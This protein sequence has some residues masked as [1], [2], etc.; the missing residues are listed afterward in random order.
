MHD[1]ILF[2][3]LGEQYNPASSKWAQ[4]IVAPCSAKRKQKHSRNYKTLYTSLPSLLGHSNK[5]FSDP[6][7][8]KLSKRIL[9]VP[10]PYGDDGPEYDINPSVLYPSCRQATF[11][12]FLSHKSSHTVPHS[13]SGKVR[14]STLPS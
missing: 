10:G 2:C 3:L 7:H 5:L 6:M 14:T 4:L 13:P 8:L 12:S 9:P 11:P 1:I